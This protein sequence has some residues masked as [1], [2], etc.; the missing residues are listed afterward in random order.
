VI[1]VSRNEGAYLRRTVHSLHESLSPRDEIIVVDDQSTDGSAE[2]LPAT[3][4][5]VRVLRPDARLGVAGA[6]NYGARHANGD[7]LVFSDAHIEVPKDWAAPMV[8]AL[9]A[10]DAGAAGAGLCSLE[11][12]T[13]KGVCGGRWCPG[14]RDH[15]QWKWLNCRDSEPYP[16][17]LLSG[18]FLAMRRDV[19]NAVKGFDCGMWMYGVEDS[20]LSVRLWTLGYQCLAVPR[21]LVAHRFSRPDRSAACEYKSN[22]EIRI[23]NKLR[24]AVLHFRTE[25]IARA[26]QGFA[27]MRAFPAAYARLTVGDAWVR[28]S[29]I[30][31]MRAHDD[32][33][34]F[35][36]FESSD[37]PPQSL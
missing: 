2:S 15:L 8:D 21:V 5:G 17:P 25:R 20:E 23:H 35:Q 9:A 28:R 26:L 1:I 31:S 37:S 32:D 34:Y 14:S 36:R 7:I 18:G 13:G 11:H 19:F 22:L 30:H 6:R 4:A 3:Y 16:V 10:P 12:R 29:E 33:W 27:P 24:L